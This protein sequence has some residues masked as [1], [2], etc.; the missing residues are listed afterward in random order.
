M[1]KYLAAL[2]AT[3]LI[4]MTPHALAA[5]STD[6]SVTG[7]I[8]PVA[9][10]PSLSNGGKIDLG[11]I[12]VKEL[13]PTA[14]TIIS[15]APMQLTIACDGE[16]RLALK[17]TDNRPNTAL[18]DVYLGLGKTP[19]DEKLGFINIEIKQ[20]LADSQVAQSISSAD[21]GATWKRSNNIYKGTI[22]SVGTTADHQTP[23]LV[24]DVVMDLS[25]MTTIARTDSLT[26]DNEVAI[27]GSATIDVIYI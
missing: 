9:C 15:R 23:I 24:R 4:G 3:A 20:T 19:A 5:S 14:D 18:Y 13:Q 10:T 22:T 1:K 8:T 6:L 21:E 12:S 7:T 26:L 16:T 25:V 11:K 17:T 27:D 2:S